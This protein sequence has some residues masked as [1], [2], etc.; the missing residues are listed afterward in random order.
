MASHLPIFWHEGM[1]LRPQ[2]FQAAERHLDQQIERSAKWDLHHNWGLRSIDINE[3]ALSSYRFEV[4]DLKGRLHDGTLVDLAADASKLFLDL[5]AAFIERNEPQVTVYL[6]V[7]VLNLGRANVS[8]N[9]SAD[10]ARYGTDAQDL[11]DEN[12]GLNPQPLQVRRLNLKLL[13][14]IQDMTG[15]VTLPIAR[16]KRADIAEGVPQL[17]KTYIPPLLACTAW[18]PLYTEILDNVMGRLNQKTELL[19]N[20]ITSRN[21]SFD[22]TSQGDRRLIE[23]MRIMNEAVAVC[24]MLFPAQGVHPFTTYLELCRLVGSLSI[25][26]LGKARTPELPMYDHDNLGE[27]FYQAAKHI[28]NLLGQDVEPEYKERPF[29]GAGMRMEVTGIESQWLETIWQ[30]FVGVESPLPAEECRMLLTRA[31]RL[32]MKLG[33]S[34]RVDEIFRRGEA[35]LRFAYTNTPPRALPRKS[36]LIYFQIDRDSQKSDWDH[37]QRTLSIALRL[38]ERLIVGNIQ[39]QRKLTI[40]TGTQQTSME[41]T[42]FVVKPDR[43]VTTPTRN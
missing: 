26:D 14:S 13:L 43:T 12:T 41:F 17:D 31:G 15:Y 30:M 20:L 24:R 11:E 27:C 7:P 39:G 38:N 18:K 34:E 25:L 10:T 1:F 16:L 2:H 3:D 32:D 23:Q 35:G 9:G 19:A 42:L 6:A 36:G 21:L 22:S 37:V 28:H 40:N 4:R 33:A 8:Q 5:K 29:K